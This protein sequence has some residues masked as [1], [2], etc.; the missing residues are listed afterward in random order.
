MFS[1]AK[2]WELLLLV[3]ALCS[4]AKDV[5][6][7]CEERQGMRGG[8]GESYVETAKV[9]WHG[10]MAQEYTLETLRSKNF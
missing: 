3:K 8:M 9:L 6:A 2:E 10:D 1:K 5:G 7:R 4:V